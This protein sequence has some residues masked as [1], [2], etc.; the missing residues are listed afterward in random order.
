MRD[1]GIEP[2]FQPKIWVQGAAPEM[3][4]FSFR[5]QE[6]GFTCHSG[7]SAKRK[8]ASRTNIAQKFAIG[9]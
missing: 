1:A 4:A 3:P 5:L 2:A 9:A 7:L 6:R 8:R